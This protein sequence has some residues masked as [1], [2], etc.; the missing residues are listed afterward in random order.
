[1][2]EQILSVM[3]WENIGLTRSNVSATQLVFSFTLL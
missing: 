3:L 1:M 2:A